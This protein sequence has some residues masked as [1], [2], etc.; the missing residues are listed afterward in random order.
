MKIIRKYIYRFTLVTASLVN[1]ESVSSPPVR[2]SLFAL[3]YVTTSGWGLCPVA[4]QYFVHEAVRRMRS[5]SPESSL[6]I[7]ETTSSSSDGVT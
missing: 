5:P 3:T 1:C 6:V 2:V 4:L 7:S